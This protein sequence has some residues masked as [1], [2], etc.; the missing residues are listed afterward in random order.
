MVQGLAIEPQST[1]S[2]CQLW[3]NKTCYQGDGYQGD[4][5]QG[6]GYQGGGY[7]GDGY[8]GDGYHG[9][10]HTTSFYFK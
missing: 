2:L 8:H 3:V 9:D 6:D 7:H 10:L 5:Y 4:G 1:F